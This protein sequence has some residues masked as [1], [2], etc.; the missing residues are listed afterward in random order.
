MINFW[1]KMYMLYGTDWFSA[2]HLPNSQFFYEYYRYTDIPEEL[3]R[4]GRMKELSYIE[5]LDG[6]PYKIRFTQKF[7]EYIGEE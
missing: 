5:T 7:I 3:F 2:P 1:K 6:Y 4:V